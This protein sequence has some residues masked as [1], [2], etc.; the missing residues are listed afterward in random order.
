MMMTTMYRVLIEA[1]NVLM[2]FEEEGIRRSGFVQTYYIES[3]SADAAA[4]EALRRV[5]GDRE[6]REQI[7][8]PPDSPPRFSIYEV[9]RCT[10]EEI[11]EIEANPTGRASFPETSWSRLTWW[12]RKLRGRTFAF[13][14]VSA[15]LIAAPSLLAAARVARA[16]A[17]TPAE[18]VN[19]TA[20]V[21]FAYDASG[22]ITAIGDDRFAYDKAGRLVE[23][24]VNGAPRTYQYD[25][26]GNR[27]ACTHLPG[28]PSQSD[29]QFGVQVDP[30]T[31]RTTGAQHD[32][33]GNV[34]TFAGHAYT[35]DETD[36]PTRDDGGAFPREFLYTADDERIA[37]SA[38]GELK[39]TLRDLGGK[40]LRE[41]T[42]DA[43]GSSFAWK[44]DYVYRDGQLLASRHVANLT[45]V[46]YYYHLD[47][48]GSPRRVTDHNNRLAGFH[49][50]FAFGPEV[51]GGLTEPMATSLKYTGHERDQ[52]GGVEGPGT[53]DYMH[54]RYYASAAARFLSVDRGDSERLGS[55]QTWNRYAYAL[56]NPI[57][58]FDPD[59]REW[60]KFA[61][62]IGITRTLEFLA[63]RS[64]EVKATLD[65][66]DGPNRPNLEFAKG[67]EL[68]KLDD[69]SD[70]NE[71]GNFKANPVSDFTYDVSKMKGLESELLPKTGQFLA[72]A[73]YEGGKITFDK[74]VN[75]NVNLSTLTKKDKETLRIIIHELGHANL[76]ATNMVL[77]LQL[78]AED[79]TKDI[80][81]DDRE[82]EKDAIN[83]Q[84]RNCR[85]PDFCDQ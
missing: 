85:Y 12:L 2:D 31:N 61:D 26:F 78:T 37:T 57:K 19:W 83:Y 60:R 38:A 3:G 14:I 80:K 39:W 40:V 70:M 34:K 59:G 15:L 84:K 54:A 50:Y 4:S 13:A 23:A 75:L 76:A 36:M 67:K 63:A 51:P 43:A 45:P 53:L 42:S 29:C 44:K 16:T 17:T 81:H 7:A 69:G 32:G 30:A 28:T 41:V 82:V 11:E 68:G 52:A 72:T 79:K 9:E 55:P 46:T 35:Y 5:A 47:H 58:V 77:Y 6:L 73:K 18:A 74:S 21:T 24:E 64:P 65:L 56:N 8:N 71:G 48:L 1:H 22:N 27:I 66:H 20:G 62:K 33:R 10:P 49:D 25:A